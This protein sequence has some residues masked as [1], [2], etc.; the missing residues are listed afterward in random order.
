M[1]FSRAIAGEGTGETCTRDREQREKRVERLER[2]ELKLLA[3]QG[4]YACHKKL[5]QMNVT[6]L[7]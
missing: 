5:P 7:Y 2:V 3:D 6:T 4:N 1:D